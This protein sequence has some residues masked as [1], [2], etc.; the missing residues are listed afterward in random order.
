MTHT[1]AIRKLEYLEKEI[2]SL[3]SA[4]ATGLT[5]PK[6]DKTT[7]AFLDK[8][9]GWEDSRGTEEIIA[10]IYSTRLNSERGENVFGD[11]MEE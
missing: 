9:G 5:G 6:D 1:D 3:R 8:C 4:L 2:S 11:S 10:D 7:I